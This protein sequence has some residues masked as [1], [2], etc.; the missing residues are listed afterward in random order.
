ME[1]LAKSYN[2]VSVKLCLKLIEDND[3]NIAFSPM[4]IASALTMVYLGTKGNTEAQMSEVSTKML[5]SQ[6]SNC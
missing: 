1:A 4:S 6:R 3:Q 5:Y 2:E